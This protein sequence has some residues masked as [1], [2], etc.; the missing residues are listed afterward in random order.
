MKLIANWRQSWRLW[1]VRVSAIATAL[2][3]FMLAAPDQALA[4]WAVLPADLQELIPGRT[5]IAA[6]LFVAS[7]V[8]RLIKQREA[9]HGDR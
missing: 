8:A 4:V 2:F 7:L 1:S 3:T 5:A 9:V 6:V